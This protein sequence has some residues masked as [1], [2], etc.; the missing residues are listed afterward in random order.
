MQK[1]VTKAA[2]ALLFTA[3][4]LLWAT[5]PAEGLDLT[6]SG[7]IWEDLNLDG[8]RQDAEPGLRTSI[9]LSGPAAAT[10]T[11]GADGSYR[12]RGLAAG[13]YRLALGEAGQNF[14]A[15]YPVSTVRGPI[16]VDVALG[17]E[18][19]DRM[20]FGLTRNFSTLSGIAWVDANR[21]VEP[22]VHAFVDGRLCSFPRPSVV[23]P[24]DIGPGFYQIYFPPQ[25][26]LASC[27]RDGAVVSF[28]VNGRPANETI[29]FPERTV[30]VADPSPIRPP[31]TPGPPR[32]LTL[33]SG[34]AFAV[35]GGSLPFEALLRLGLRGPVTATIAG[36]EC[37]LNHGAFGGY[38]IS[39]LPESLATGC[40]SEAALV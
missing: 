23:S 38:Q 21:T 33:T 16:A 37:S 1:S 36:R 12:F 8:Q 18:S 3:L 27:A 39:V 10:M 20:D 17:V 32:N 25:E 9:R 30:S 7:V 29:V 19:L 35:Y 34:P 26:L 4:A 15:T 11:T 28:T 6:I 31:D 14:L 40:G 24:T 13:Q 22:E 2:L 5:S